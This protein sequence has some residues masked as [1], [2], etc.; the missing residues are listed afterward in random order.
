MLE[1]KYL[2]DSTPN[3]DS[4]PLDV[5]DSEP[6]PP[7]IQSSPV[8]DIEDIWKKPSPVG[9]SKRIS[10]N[11]KK[12]KRDDHVENDFGDKNASSW[13]EAL[14]PQPSCDHFQVPIFLEASSFVIF[15]LFCVTSTLSFLFSLNVGMAGVSEEEVGLATASSHSYSQR[16]R[17]RK[18]F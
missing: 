12:R 17:T 14:G 1:D 13:R 2:N 8:A 5:P 4:E 10:F 16:R 18:T 7:D 3:A 6:P 9:N 15:Q 11:K